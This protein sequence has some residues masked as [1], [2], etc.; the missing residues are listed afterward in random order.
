M[1]FIAAK[2]SWYIEEVVQ[3]WHDVVDGFEPIDCTE[4]EMTVY[5]EEGHKF[6]IGPDKGLAHQKK[7]FLSSVDV[8]E[9]DFKNGE[10]F[11]VDTQESDQNVLRAMLI[12]YIQRN[13]LPTVVE[14]DT[15]SFRQIIDSIK[16]L[17]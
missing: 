5:D 9:W 16:Q 1:Y 8:G 11:L 14:P 3:D 15:L 2:D 13:K 10:P 17:V 12:V 7:G 4:E 6:F